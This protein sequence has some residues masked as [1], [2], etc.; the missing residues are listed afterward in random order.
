MVRHSW[1][2]KV[3][4]VLAEKKTLVRDKLLCLR[5][6]N[7]SIA[8]LSTPFDSFVSRGQWPEAEE[9]G[10]SLVMASGTPFS[11]PLLYLCLKR[12]DRRPG[13]PGIS[14]V[15]AS[16]IPSPFCLIGVPEEE[17]QEARHQPCVGLCYT[18]TLLSYRCA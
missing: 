14:P 3:K 13:R 1:K 12:K 5:K 10:A 15:L 18:L 8:S 17:G 16:A 11:S 4:F 9:A 6:N 7:S 2:P